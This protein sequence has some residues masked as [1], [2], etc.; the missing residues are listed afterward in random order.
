MSTSN[1]NHEASSSTTVKKPTTAYMFFCK[2]QRDA[3]K[4]TME[5]AKPKSKIMAKDVMIEL[6]LRWDKIKW[7]RNLA[8]ELKKY[9]DMARDDKERY[10]NELS[11]SKGIKVIVD[12]TKDDQEDDYNGPIPTINKRRESSYVFYCQQTRDYIKIANPVMKGIDVT[13]KL[14][15][16]WKTMS[17]NDK[18]EWED[19]AN[20]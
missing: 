19:K 4:T 18:Q 13:K 15:A 6:G 7:D 20:F 17:I 5:T 10:D 8:E 3:V 14:A 2:I 1:N 12:H 9:H 16:M 11:V